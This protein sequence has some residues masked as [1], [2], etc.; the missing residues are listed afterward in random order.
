M[1]R[2]K[3]NRVNESE[4]RGPQ[5]FPLGLYGQGS[6]CLRW[7]A[8]DASLY[9]A[10]AFPRDVDREFLAP[11]VVQSRL[12]TRDQAG[13]FSGSGMSMRRAFCRYRLAAF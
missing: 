1:D 11:T 9:H 13:E 4:L 5:G 8:A 6:H 7:A 2:E 10:V 12:F 3:G